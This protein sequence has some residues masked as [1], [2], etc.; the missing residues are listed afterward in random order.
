[1]LLMRVFLTA[2]GQE[3]ERCFELAISFLM[4]IA[5]AWPS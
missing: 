3:W 4:F 5:I 2:R 1:M